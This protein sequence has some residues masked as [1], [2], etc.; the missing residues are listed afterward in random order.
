MILVEVS[1]NDISGEN[2]YFTN[3]IEWKEHKIIG[4]KPANKFQI[5]RRCHNKSF[6]N[7]IFFTEPK[8]SYW[9][10][11]KLTIQTFIYY[12]IYSGARKVF[13]EKKFDLFWK[14]NA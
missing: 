5:I 13:R 6:V 1:T 10:D 4:F 8:I 3:H 11:E 2:T 9:K 14:S 7:I 12:L